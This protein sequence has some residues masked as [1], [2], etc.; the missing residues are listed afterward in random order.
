MKGEC[1]NTKDE[2]AVKFITNYEHYLKEHEHRERVM[3]LET[4]KNERLRLVE[5][6]DSFNSEKEVDE[7]S[8]EAFKIN[9]SLQLM[10][11]FDGKKTKVK[12]SD[13][14]YAIVMVLADRNLD[15]IYREEKPNKLICAYPSLP[16]GP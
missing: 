13:Y 8:P 2:M 7:S 12:L 9:E 10:N 16:H 6:I 4:D 1:A 5:I 3:G 11:A 15:A 14:K